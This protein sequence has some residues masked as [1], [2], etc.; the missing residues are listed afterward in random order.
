MGGTKKEMYQTRRK[1]SQR[2]R[3][4]P[5]QRL[6]AGTS[7]KF[8]LAT[9]NAVESASWPSLGC[10]KAISW[11]SAVGDPICSASTLRDGTGLDEDLGVNDQ[12]QGLRSR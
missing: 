5:E 11:K 12:L 8:R 1:G 9:Q 4:E 3:E 10:K 6:V 2:R 7:G